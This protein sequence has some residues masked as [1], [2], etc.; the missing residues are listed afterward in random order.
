MKQHSLYRMTWYAV[1]VALAIAVILAVY[2]IGWEYSTRRYLK[3][4]SDAVIPASDS[5]EKKVQAILDW[6]AHGPARQT[7]G[8]PDASVP[9]RDPTETLNYDSLLQVCGTATNAFVN[10]A[11]S[12]GLEARRVLLLDSRNLTKHVSAEVL[13]DGRWIVV[14]PTYRTIFR[15]AD[16][17]S[18]TRSELSDPAVFAAAIQR[19]PGYNAAYTYER[20]AHLRKGRLSVFGAPLFVIL[21]RLAPGWTESST[22]SLLAERESLV[23][24]LASILLLMFLFLLRV[25]LRWYG[26][27]RLGVRTNR[28]REQLVRAWSAFLRPADPPGVSKLFPGK[29]PTN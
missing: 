11:D 25:S 2:S 14:D 16:G 6:M 12:G 26:E 27:K 20:T 8:A 13:V 3:G 15:G 17:K 5:A 23:A 18:V 4:F 28:V 1:N 21:N 7:V 24:V 22:V 29:G 9:D 19:V 10:L